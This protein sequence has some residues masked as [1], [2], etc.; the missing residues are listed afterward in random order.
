M[1]LRAVQ[2]FFLA[3]LLLPPATAHVTVEPGSGDSSENAT[4]LGIPPARVFDALHPAGG[5]HYYRVFLEE[6]QVVQLRLLATP[7]AFLANDPPSVFIVSP[8]VNDA[9]LR[10]AGLPLPDGAGVDGFAGNP[11]APF[12]VDWRLPARFVAFVDQ[13]F[14]APASGHFFVV[15]YSREGGGS[16]SFAVEKSGGSPILDA[17][18]VV[19]DRPLAYATSGE[20]FART[21][22]GFAL[23]AVV[24]VGLAIGSWRRGERFSGVAKSGALVASILFA[25]SA[26][27][28]AWESV[29]VGV[30]GR[31]IAL[32]ALSAALAA[33]LFACASRPGVPSWRV[34][35]VVIAAGL[36]GL[37]S[38]GGALI[39]PVLAILTSLI[40]DEAGAE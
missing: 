7:G 33:V 3:T 19:T 21:A 35:S 32:A 27:S 20:S 17:Y 29:R 25:A 12:V 15:V 6:G 26:S 28:L 31:T 16:Y 14:V 10:P 36:V 4:A 1:R 11:D 2:I 22:A 9:G 37:A 23:G 34:R 30:D 38:W 18:L 40:P 24:V 39:G 5:Y 13:P 8:L